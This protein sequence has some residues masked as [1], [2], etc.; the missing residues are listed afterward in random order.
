MKEK[1][2][3]FLG[4]FGVILWYVLSIV[5]CALP[6]AMIGT[7]FWVTL[8]LIGIEMSFPLSS[9]IFWI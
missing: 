6:F 3:G 4:G 9:V 1:M 8:I 7:R 5:I 2:L